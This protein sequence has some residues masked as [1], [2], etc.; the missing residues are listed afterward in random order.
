MELVG[1]VMVFCDFEDNLYI[2][3]TDGKWNI[4]VGVHMRKAVGCQ[5][6]VLTHFN[7]LLDTNP[8]VKA[9]GE[10]GMDRMSPRILGQSRIT[11][12]RKCFLK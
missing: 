4:A 9:L 8:L 1:G 7:A 6:R 10:F 3:L 5:E 2:S 11:S 12:S